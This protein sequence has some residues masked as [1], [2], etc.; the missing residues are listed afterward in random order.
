M[1]RQGATATALGSFLRR[2]GDAP[3]D[4]ARDILWAT[5]VLVAKPYAAERDGRGWAVV[6]AG[7]R[8]GLW[9][10][11]SGRVVFDAAGRAH[12]LAAEGGKLRILGD[13]PCRAEPCAVSTPGLDRAAP[14][15]GERRLTVRVLGADAATR[16][17]VSGF[18]AKALGDKLF[19][20]WG[21]PQGSAN[22]TALRGA[23]LVFRGRLPAG[24]GAAPVLHLPSPPVSLR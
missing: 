16:L 24:G 10:L 4:T 8:A 15:P 12:A 5:S 9:P 18:P 2:Y 14:M 1:L 13:A 17:Y 21:M 3:R 20:Y 22:V 11:A 7:W 6:G 23:R 19:E